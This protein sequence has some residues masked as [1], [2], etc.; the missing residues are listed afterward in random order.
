MNYY[1]TTNAADFNGLRIN[2]GNEG[3]FFCYDIIL[4]K[5]HERIQLMTKYSRVMFVRADLRLPHD[6]QPSGNNEEVSHLFKIMKENAR[7]HNV[8]FH[9]VWVR[10][11]SPDGKPHY[12]LV[13]LLDASRV[14]NYVAFLN[15]LERVWGHVLNCNA[16]GLVHRCETDQFGNYTGNGIILQQPTRQATGEE[17]AAQEHDFWSKLNWITE[18]ASYLAKVRQKESTPH[19]VRRFG[20]S[21]L[22]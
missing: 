6:H 14:S 12:H 19:R 20:A 5:I 15:E 21:Q 7:T 22:D 16:T 4:Q 10:E 2:T 11:S 3:Q 13:I 9:F 18:W 17:R 8:T 1:S